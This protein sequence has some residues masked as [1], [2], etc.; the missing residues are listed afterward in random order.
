MY[1]DLI[2]NEFFTAL[3]EAKD[4]GDSFLKNNGITN[5]EGSSVKSQ[6]ISSKSKNSFATLQSLFIIIVK[7][8]VT[9]SEEFFRIFFLPSAKNVLLTLL[10]VPIEN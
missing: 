8:F 10:Q 2:V 3:L 5:Y 1:T 7:Y 6:K 9:S 4:L